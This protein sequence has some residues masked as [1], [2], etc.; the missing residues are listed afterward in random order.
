MVRK[1]DVLALE[2]QLGVG[3]EGKTA[4]VTGAGRG[5][6]LA[7]ARLLGAAGARVA[8]IDV[9]EA[10]A[11][12]A[13][14]GLVAEGLDA[15]PY[16]VDMSDRSAVA[17]VV[18]EVADAFGRLDVCVDVAGGSAP[19][20][21]ME[22]T[23]EHWNQQLTMNLFHHLWI[24]QAS[25]RAMADS[26]GGAFVFVS[27]VHSLF[28]VPERGAY[29]VARAGQVSLTKTLGCELAEHGIRVNA[30]A[31]GAIDSP[32]VTLNDTPEKRRAHES[33]IPM[34][35]RGTSDEAAKAILFLASDLAS[36]VTGQL[37]VVDGGMSVLSHLNLAKAG[38]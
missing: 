27:S 34:G 13:A 26:G 1:A 16:V 24:A 22:A 28:G 3:L 20:P 7:T 6:G 8:I 10:R 31:L 36:Y 21:L 5:I 4:L 38:M 37:L 11:H 29:A 23:E 15:L 18:A 30:V 2:Q 32:K 33:V 12:S 35:R 19:S 25:W 17:V 14:A 9:D